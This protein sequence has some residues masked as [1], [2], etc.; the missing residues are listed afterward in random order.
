M[1]FIILQSQNFRGVFRV[2][3][4]KIHV[5]TQKFGAKPYITKNK[6]SQKKVCN[7]LGFAPGGYL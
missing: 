4:S 3:V 5:T 6:L 1:V 7:C 2:A